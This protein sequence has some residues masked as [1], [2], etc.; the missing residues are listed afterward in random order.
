MRA[1]GRARSMSLT[2]RLTVAVLCLTTVAL[3]AF[4]AVGTTLLHRSL[5][6]EVDHRLR[7]LGGTGGPERPPSPDDETPQPLLP[8]DLRVLVLDADGE[9]VRT[10][11]QSEGDQGVPD[12][13]ET[14]ADALR[15][16]SGEP[17]ELPDASG[18][19]SWRVLATE[20]G[21]GTFHLAAQSLDGVDSTLNQ[22]VLI[23]AALGAA[24]LLLLGAG[25]VVTVR[26]QL[27]PLK[28]FEATAQ[29]IAA[30]D[31]GRRVPD[32]GT[33]T[34]TDRLAAALNTMLEELSRALAERDRSVATTKRFVSDASH[35]LRTP[36]S[37]IRGFAELY[38]QGR[39]RG[40][41]GADTRTERWVSR[42]E[43]EAVR[44]GRMVDDLLVLSRFD[45]APVVD[46]CDV[47]LAGIVGDAVRSARARAPEREVALEA[48]EPVHAVADAVRIGQ[49]LENLLGN[50]LV[51]TPE[52][53]PVRVRL[54]RTDD[55][56]P[57]GPAHAGGLPPGVS[58]VAV[59]SVADEGPGIPREELPH[60]FDRFYQVGGQGRGS[61]TG[62]GLAI[63]AA[64]VAAH[65]GYLTAEC[66]AGGG[67]V[68]RVVLPLG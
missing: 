17:F 44:M 37:S 9:P 6:E 65:E 46:R 61:G 48:A 56:P 38:R 67:S 26:G 4:G 19:G 54:T 59:I 58:E 25:A 53:T 45:E 20:R 32:H 24:V 22:L 33:D 30:G 21:D 11:G 52:G 10:V 64:F 47:E 3:A 68:F 36:L 43:E 2:A 14:D 16:R 31:F 23:E 28:R 40:V 55:A 29:T 35:E 5:V 1:G 12:L 51:H 27:Q 50:A 66:P 13:S 63:S 49:V 34:E 62:L 39:E 60:V 57:P 42:I 41:V 15:E 7:G 18:D 8:T